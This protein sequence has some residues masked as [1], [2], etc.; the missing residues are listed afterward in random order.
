MKILKTTILISAL[1]LFII[2]SVNASMMAFPTY[3]ACMQAGGGLKPGIE[4]SVTLNDTELLAR[5]TPCENLDVKCCEIVNDEGACRAYIQKAKI[6]R[7][8]VPI[9]L[10]G[11]A[12]L[13]ILSI[14]YL[15][16]G[17]KLVK[18]EKKYKKIKIAWVIF[19][20]GIL[21]ILLFLLVMLISLRA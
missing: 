20:I 2:Q 6:A 1:M 19:G 16:A 15:I 5:I 8:G 4:Q 17:K 3:H 12:I 9:F 7:V 10:I 18:E 14:I 13:F 11:Y 21:L